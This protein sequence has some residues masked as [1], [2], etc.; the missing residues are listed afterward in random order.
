VDWSA[1][2]IQRY[3][4]FFATLT[5]ITDP[6]GN[7]LYFL[8]FTERDEPAQCRKTAAIASACAALILTF[9]ALTGGA[10]LDF[11]SVSLPA[12][13]IAGGI[14]FFIYGLQ[15]L[16][17][18]PSSIRTTAPEEEESLARENVALV[19]LAIPLIAG[20]GAIT[21]VMVWRERFSTPEHLVPFLIAIAASCLVTF[22]VFA[23]GRAVR[24]LLGVSGIRVAERLMGLFLAVMAVEFVVRGVQALVCNC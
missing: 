4:T 2:A 11:F 13:L 20:P 24:R 6:L 21:T 7:L 14:V 3:L 16:R 18:L 5:V 12:F 1:P 8:V 23:F 17:L 9:F 15:M 22:L 19:P 10:V